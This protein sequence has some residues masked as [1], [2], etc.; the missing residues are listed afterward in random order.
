MHK[1]LKFIFGINLYMFWNSSSVHRQE[2]FTVHTAMIYY[3]CHTILL[4]A[5]EQDQDRTAIPSW[6]CSQA[7]SKPVWHISLLCVQ[8]KIPDDGQRNSLKH[9]EF[10]SKSKFERLE[11]LVGFIIRI[12]HVARSPERQTLFPN[13]SFTR[14]NISTLLA[15]SLLP[16]RHCLTLMNV[17]P[18]YCVVTTG[19]CGFPTISYSR[20]SYW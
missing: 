10:Y 13:F 4:I 18:V 2:F 9:V 7:V 20:V 19:G 1:F 11:H 15:T 14:W 3:V 8:W 16:I 17:A 12:Y 6:S 5:C